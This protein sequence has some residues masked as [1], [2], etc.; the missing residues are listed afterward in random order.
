MRNEQRALLTGSL[1]L[2]LL[3]L[4]SVAVLAGGRMA[5]HTR[6]V[7][8]LKAVGGTPGLVA[9]V[10]LAENL[11]LA[12]VAAA[13]GLAIGWLAAP[14]LTSPGAGLVGAAGAPSQ[15]RIDGRGGG[16]R[17][18][19][20]GGRRDARARDPRRAHQHGARARRRGAA[21][22]APGAADRDLGALPVPLLLGLR[23]A[24]RRPAPAA[25]RVLSI[26]VTVTGIVA[27][28][29][30]HAQLSA[31]QVVGSSGLSNPRAD[32]LN[33]VLPVIT[34][35]L[36]ALAALNAIFTTWATVLDARHS[37]ALARA[38][39][40]TPQ[41]VSAG[42][43]AAQVL[44]ALPAPSSASRE[45]FSCSTPCLPRSRRTCPSCGSSP[46]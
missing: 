32:R 26:A 35:M 14:L 16:W 45:G 21:A 5:E 44:P 38:L 36:V 37:S 15:S 7:G 1:L 22:P 9:G 11:A 40:A 3:A 13:V 25:L 43:S 23:L 24:A 33:Q 10:L 39:G 30:S 34:V 18:P 8:L 31:Q 4:A 20:R 17:R 46:C 19:R 29:A 12:L 41:Q 28:L 42:L 27:V 2:S 6:R